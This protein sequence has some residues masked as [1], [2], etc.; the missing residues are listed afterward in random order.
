MLDALA[1]R[2]LRE[3]AVLLVAQLG[4]DDRRNRLVDHLLGG[5]AEKARRTGIPRRDASLER[6][7]DDRVIGRIDDCLAERLHAIRALLCFAQS[8]L[9][10]QLTRDV[11][12]EAARANE[13]A[14]VE[15]HVRR[16]LHVANR[17]ILAAHSRGRVAQRL[18]GTQSFQNG[19]RAVGIQVGLA[20]LMPDVFITRIAEHLE[21][22]AISPEDHAIGVN[23]MDPV[24]RILEKIRK[25]VLA[26]LEQ[27]FGRL[28]LPGLLLEKPRT[29]RQVAKLAKLH[30]A[31]RRMLRIRYCM[32]MRSAH[33]VERLPRSAIHVGERIRAE[34]RE[35]ALL[36]EC[37]P[38]LFE[39]HCSVV[40]A[41]APQHADDLA[42]NHDR[43]ITRLRGFDDRTDDRLES[44]RVGPAFDLERLDSVIGIERHVSAHVAQRRKI[45]RTRVHAQ[46]ELREMSLR[47]DD[48][49]RRTRAEP[50]ANE[51][52]DG[53]GKLAVAFVELDEVIV[54]DDA[55]RGTIM[56]G[57]PVQSSSRVAVR[58]ELSSYR[59]EHDVLN[60]RATGSR[61]RF[62]V[63]KCTF[64]IGNGANASESRL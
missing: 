47:R 51:C 63:F 50:V 23:A 3:N 19:R 41:I 48:N 49:R 59:I 30:L 38:E 53:F 9:G 61:C 54:R 60:P 14:V 21:L 20:D 34:E 12:R 11:T 6:L 29:S 62:C 17:T 16:D 10:L 15:A 44:A 28:P 40:F 25:L 55:V 52:R 57:T 42:E 1:T 2:E 46:L 8:L 33:R 36:P 5:V 27:L 64:Y 43:R 7:A 22:G 26:H 37:V 4:G 18:A 32:R 24:R 31:G 13:G 35:G 56:P 45:E 39:A 58:A